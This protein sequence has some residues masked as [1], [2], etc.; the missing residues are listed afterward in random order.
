MRRA[1]IQH[2]DNSKTT[3]N[4]RRFCVVRLA[5][6]WRRKALLSR[7]A[8]ER[9]QFATDAKKRCRVAHKRGTTA[10]FR[11]GSGTVARMC[12]EAGARLRVRS[13]DA[14]QVFSFSF[15][16]LLNL[17]VRERVFALVR[18]TVKPVFD[19]RGNTS[20]NEP[21]RRGR[22]RTEVMRTEF[23]KALAKAGLTKNVLA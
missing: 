15:S 8:R 12:N 23:C 4:L 1:G 16:D 9:G 5:A 13:Y 19:R 7:L 2:G 14:E 21:A 22:N 18:A 20:G 6:A 10:D 3:L 11:P 17:E